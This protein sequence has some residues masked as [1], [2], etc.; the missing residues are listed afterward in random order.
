MP[1][2]KKLLAKMHRAPGVTEVAFRASYGLLPDDVVDWNVINEVCKNMA[3][4][5]SKS[6][7]CGLAGIA[8]QK[9]ITWEQRF[10]AVEEALSLARTRRLA[11]LETVLLRDDAKMPQI[12]SRIFALKNADPDEWKDRPGMGPATPGLQQNITVITGVPEAP[13]RGKVIEHQQTIQIEAAAEGPVDY[14]GRAADPET[15][16]RKAQG[17]QGY[18]AT[19]DPQ[20]QEAAKVAVEARLAPAP[21]GYGK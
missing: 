2:P 6:A 8:L 10:P 7:S 1:L 11:A 9:V 21:E 16:I 4:G 19:Q 13:D 18:E 17:Q 14:A 5:Y 3:E 20:R 15:Y 12:V